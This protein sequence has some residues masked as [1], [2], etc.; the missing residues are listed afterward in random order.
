MQTYLR[1]SGTGPEFGLGLYSI[2]D[3]FSNFETNQ[4]F[5]RAVI[6]R[7]ALSNPRAIQPAYNGVT[8]LHG[9]FSLL[10]PTYSHL[11]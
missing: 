3:N 1:V 2:F 5:S 7:M 8:R 10:E 11:R 9:G 4:V 6:R